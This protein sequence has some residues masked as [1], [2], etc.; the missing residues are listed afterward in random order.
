M[1]ARILRRI[2][3]LREVGEVSFV[4]VADRRALVF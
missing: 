4:S 3:G 1:A 2:K